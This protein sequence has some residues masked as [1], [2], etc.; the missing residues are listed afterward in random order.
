V[1]VKR[2]LA[3][4]LNDFLDP[5]RAKRAA[6]VGDNPNIVVRPLLPDDRTALVRIAFNE[7]WLFGRAA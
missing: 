5:I 3:S 7:G 1:E 4:A 2:R 6:L